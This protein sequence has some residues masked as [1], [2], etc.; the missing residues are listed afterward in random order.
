[1]GIKVYFPKLKVIK[2]CFQRNH[3]NFQKWRAFG[4]GSPGPH[5]SYRVDIQLKSRIKS[6]IQTRPFFKLFV[7]FSSK[8]EKNQ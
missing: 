1:M 7:L 6:F 8:L 3:E 2:D 4:L 5:V